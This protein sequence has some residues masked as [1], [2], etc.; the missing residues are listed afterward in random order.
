MTAAFPTLALDGAASWAADNGFDALELA[1]W[2]SSG[3]EQRRYAGV[4]HV[5]VEALDVDAVKRE[6]DGRGLEISSL[7]YYPNPL[8]PDLEVRARPTP[9]CAAWSTPPSGWASPTV[10]T[11]VGRDSRPLGREP[12]AT[13]RVWPGLV[14]YAGER[15]VNVAIENCPM[16]FSGDE[17]PGGHNLAYSP[18]IWRELFRPFPTRTSGSTSIRPTWSG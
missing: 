4:C 12:G 18:A 16:I 11:F 5:D 2:P 17:W 6:V 10:G 14:R 1:C 13:S 15:G 7:A 9:T 8:D 3:G